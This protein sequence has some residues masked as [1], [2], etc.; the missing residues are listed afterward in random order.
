MYDFHYNFIKNI[1][2]LNCYLLKQTVL[3]LKLHQKM[4]MKNFLNANACLTLVNI[5]QN[6]LIRLTKKLLVK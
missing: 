2:M 5:N 6:F 4:F 1:L 3:P